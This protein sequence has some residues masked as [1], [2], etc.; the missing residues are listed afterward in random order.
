[1]IQPIIGVPTSTPSSA[2]H[3]HIPIMAA[4]YGPLVFHVPLHNIPQDYQT[5]IPQ[6][7]GTG[8]MT[9]QQHVDK[10][11]DFFDL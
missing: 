7:D 4:R 8:T 2:T 5:R 9:A 3:P 1:V 6:F 10:I 11:N